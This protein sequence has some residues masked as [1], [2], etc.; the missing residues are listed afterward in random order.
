[1]EWYTEDMISL[2]DRCWSGWLG[3]CLITFGLLLDAIG[4]V[5]LA[6]LLIVSKEVAVKRTVTRSIY[7]EGDPR[8][9]DTPPAKAL[10]RDSKRAIWGAGLLVLG[11]FLQIIGVWL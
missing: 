7:R 6:S 3:K 4:A 10:S 8:A 5:L 1:M 11:F 9:Y 2:L